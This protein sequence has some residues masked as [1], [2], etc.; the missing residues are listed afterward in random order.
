V[1]SHSNCKVAI[2]PDFL[3]KLPQVFR[4]RYLRT[5]S[6]YLKSMADIIAH[7]Y[8]IMHDMT[9]LE[10]S[11]ARMLLQLSAQGA[12]LDERRD[13]PGHETHPFRNLRNCWYHE[14]A[15][16]HPLESIDE[17]LKFASWKIVQ[18]YYS[19]F[20]A[21][22]SLVCCY[23]PPK[24][25]PSKTLNI[26][27]REFLCNRDRQKFFLPPVNLYLNQQGVI[28]K[29]LSEMITWNYAQE[30]KIPFIKECLESVRQEQ[31]ITTL[32]HYLKSLREWAT[33]EDA[34]LMFRL[35]GEGPKRDLDFSLERIV[36]I[37]C[38]QT[39]HYLINLFGWDS[40]E[41]QYHTF[42]EALETY[43]DIEPINLVTRFHTYQTSKLLEL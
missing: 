2:L 26:Y 38:L 7:M 15:L 4:Q 27:G 21:V 20:S 19:I 10:E 1:G 25:N 13:D 3:N 22:A 37:H 39:E 23:H 32:P 12:K 14:C 43:L 31:T 34:Y 29:E 24:R 5:H 6:V 40:V 28:P 33:Y 17:R 18:C 41:R 11:V 8:G 16:I 42:L 30:H 36:F 35:Y 9:K